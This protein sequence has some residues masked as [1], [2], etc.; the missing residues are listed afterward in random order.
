MST[1]SLLFLLHFLVPA[2][3]FLLCAVF[4]KRA[5]HLLDPQHGRDRFVSILLNTGRR[6]ALNVSQWW[7]VLWAWQGFG[8]DVV[9]GM[10]MFLLDF[11]FLSAV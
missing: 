5:R 11:L 8:A 1:K 9:R 2:V 6:V 4:Y 3:Y 10:S 7:V